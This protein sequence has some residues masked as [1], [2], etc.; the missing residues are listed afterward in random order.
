MIYFS[1]IFLLIIPL[2]FF[3]LL[4]PH[5]KSNNRGIFIATLLITIFIAF[6]LGF[7]TSGNEYFRFFDQIDTLT[8]INLFDSIFIDRGPIFGIL[9]SI[10]KTLRIPY[11]FIFF[12]ISLASIFL[13][14]MVFK[15]HTKFYVLA[16]L[17]YFSHEFALKDLIQIRMGLASAIFLLSIFYLSN[18]KY[19]K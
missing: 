10:L 14:L 5:I 3:Q 6:F 18:Q 2:T 4:L 7:K 11:E 19:L 1:V 13:H 17:F 12:M 16:L 8:N 15:R 9:I